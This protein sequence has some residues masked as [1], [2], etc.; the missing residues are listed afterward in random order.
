MSVNLQMWVKTSQHW[1]LVSEGTWWKCRLCLTHLSTITSSPLGLSC[2]LY[3]V[4]WHYLCLV[5][6]R[7]TFPEKSVGIYLKENGVKNS[8]NKSRGSAKNVRNKNIIFPW[9]KSSNPNTMWLNKWGET[10]WQFS[11]ISRLR[12]HSVAFIF[13][14]VDFWVRL[15]WQI[16]LSRQINTVTRKSY[17]LCREYFKPCNNLM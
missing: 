7:I 12:K 3:Y 16:V 11:L 9:T 4:T 17:Q 10:K 2:S 5:F 8:E 13:K 1:L 6:G 15:Q 14:I